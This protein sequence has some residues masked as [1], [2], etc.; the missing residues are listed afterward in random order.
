M[1]GTVMGF[2][3]GV[4]ICYQ[5]VYAD[6][7]DHMREFATLKAIG[8]G[9]YY[10]VGLVLEQCFYLSLLGFIPGLVISYISYRLLAMYTGLTMD[11]GPGLAG[12]VL[13][14]TAA[15]CTISGLLAVSKL[16]ATDPAELF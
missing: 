9:S 15:M 6:I 11:L 3:V 16:L 8:Y 1:V 12:L 7:A 4:V 10:F 14:A 2:V 13:L 5:I